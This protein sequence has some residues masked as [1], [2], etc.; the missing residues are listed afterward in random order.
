MNALV[1]NLLLVSLAA[2]AP[3]PPPLPPAGN[4]VDRHQATQFAAMVNN[5]AVMVR[6]MY[7]ADVSA[8]DLFVGAIRGLYD[9]AG[10][11]PPDELLQVAARAQDS[12]DLQNVLIDARMR[13]GNNPALAGPRSLFAA[14]NGFKHA[15]DPYCGLAGQ[16]VNDFV[17][18]DFDFNLGFELD[19][20]SGPRISIYRIERSISIGQLP[21]VGFFGPLPKPDAVASPAV[22]PWRIKR[23]IPGSPAQRANLKPGDLLTHVAGEEVTAEN[24]NRMFIK[25]A[26]PPS[27]GVDPMTGRALPIKRNLKFKRG[28]EAFN[29]TLATEGYVPES[30]FGVMR[31]ADGKWDCMLDR[32]YKIGYIRLGPVEQGSE[33]LFES[34]LDDLTKQGCRAL[35]LDL[36][37][38]PGGYV[39]PG[40]AIASTL[41]KPNDT[42]AQ[43]AT[44]R[45][46]PVNPPNGLA[47]PLPEV[48]RAAAP[49]AG[50]FPNTPV[51]VLVGT[52][53]TGG[54]E[55]IAAALQDNLR[56]ETMGQRTAGRAAIQNAMDA[57][58]GQLQFK[59][60]TGSTLRPNGKPRGKMPDSKPT[61]EWGIK[62]DPGLEVPVSAEVS[63]K[64]R[65]WADEHALRPGESKEA[66]QWDDPRKD[67][68]RTAALAH[69]R[70]KLDRV[71]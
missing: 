70:K 12:V 43:V 33:R 35:I 67:P 20:A 55:L 68:Y 28:Q 19:G 10:A 18:V 69:L 2:P 24:A 14:M 49:Y 3:V 45:R 39:T 54:G 59:V 9:A 4:T 40:T 56:C 16:R 58:F 63:A 26:E 46:N 13:L 37:W 34:M 48:Y 31:G 8:N 42:I 32:E 22:F 29:T 27:A 25:L 7:L 51:L 15:T 6:G 53:T 65:Q 17:S 5:T 57:G 60:T 71:K 30:V 1:L 61:D 44:Q 50:T 66:L 41:L 47:A 62:P 23:I 36:R 52:E 21:P 11:K 38:C 64:L